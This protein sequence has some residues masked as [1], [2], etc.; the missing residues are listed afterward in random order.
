MSDNYKFRAFISYSHAD[1]K[2]ASWLHKALE[3]Y[4]VP[5]YLVGEDTKF[6]PVPDRLGSVF[7]DREELSTATSLGDELTQ[8]LKDSACQIVICSPRAAKSHWT[9]EE[10]LTYKRL[11]RSERIFCLIVDGE[12][13]ASDDADTADQECFPPALRYVVGEDGVL[14]DE[15][16]EPIAAD[17]RRGKDN[18]QNAKLKLVA[19]ML[20][21]G[22]DA[23]KQREHQRKQRRMLFLTTA[24]VTGMAVTT[25]LATAA[26]FARI[27]AEEQRNRAQVEAE[28]AKRTTEF[29]VEMF[30]VSDPSESRGNTVT[31]RE[32]LENGAAR[33]QKELAD[34]PEIQATL[35]HTIGDVYRSLGLYSES[36]QLLRD[37]LTK[38]RTTYGDDNEIVAQ[39]Q[40]QLAKVLSLQAE[41]ESAE[42]LYRSALADR[43]SVV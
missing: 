3:T 13:G 27:E 37:A 24:A 19:G 28:T 32:I 21:V 18:R 26:W 14:T 9:N 17:A 1:E 29:M 36:G 41:Y 42:S 33:I 23:L 10:I 7:R 20:G 6:G 12:P 16:S 2:W 22:F 30:E 39:T 11:G 40:A 35:M 31:A 34:Q 43:K 4:R 15:R 8:A 5:K 38:R 25:V